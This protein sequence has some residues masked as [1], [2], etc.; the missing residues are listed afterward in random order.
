MIALTL[1]AQE[2]GSFNPPGV[3]SHLAPLFTIGDFEFTKQMLLVLLSVALISWFFVAAARQG[4]LVPGKLQFAGEVGYNFVRNS[5]AKDVIGGKDFMK[6]VPLLFS[7]F[8]F[9][10]INNI[11]GAIPLI[12]LP[13]FSHVGG[14]YFL[15]ALVYVIWIGVG[16]KANGL[17]YLKLAV[18]PSG[19]PWYILP[20]VVPI[21]I[22]SNFLVRPM[23]HSLRL[24]ATMLAGHLIV[25]IAGS[26]IEFLIMQESVLMKGASVLVLAGSIAMYM[27]EALIMVLQAYVFV[28]L[29]AIYIEGAV[30]ADTH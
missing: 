7:L 2:G 27:L 11:Y 14:A 21:E 10:L 15:A 25:L 6:Y 3:N 28:L 20:L 23:T 12:Q 8:F 24:F 1:P 4:K 9:I 18:V 22:I 29:T 5:V 30:H 17:R 16:I 19:V 13:S 26:G